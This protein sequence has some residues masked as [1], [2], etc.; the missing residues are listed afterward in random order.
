VRSI[1][2]R[3]KRGVEA[4]TLFQGMLFSAEEKGINLSDDHL[5]SEA[6]LMNFAGKNDFVLLILAL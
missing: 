1:K 5:V 4:R 6:I 3:Q 2:A